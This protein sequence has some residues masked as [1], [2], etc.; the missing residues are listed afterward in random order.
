MVV[1]SWS[2][3]AIELYL[4][5]TVGCSARTI[6]LAGSMNMQAKNVEYAGFHAL[7]HR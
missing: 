1:G 6:L 4:H 7:Q 3:L 2:A 5:D